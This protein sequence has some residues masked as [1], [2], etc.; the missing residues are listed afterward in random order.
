MVLNLAQYLMNN[1]CQIIFCYCFAFYLSSKPQRSHYDAAVHAMQCYV[2]YYCCYYLHYVPHPGCH[3]CVVS[4]SHCFR[5]KVNQ[6]FLILLGF[7]NTL[8]LPC[9]ALPLTF[10]WLISVLRL[11]SMCSQHTHIHRHGFLAVRVSFCYR[12]AQTFWDHSKFC[13]QL[14]K[15][16]GGFVLI[17]RRH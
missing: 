3:F 14:F 11:N 1:F 10:S 15:L 12:P 7:A 13:C 9:P 17:G 6:N 4:L 8:L 2:F 5:L 16:F